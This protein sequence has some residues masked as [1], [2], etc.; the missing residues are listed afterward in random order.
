MEQERERRNQNSNKPQ[1]AVGMLVLIDNGYMCT[2]Y[3]EY[4]RQPLP[5]GFGL[6]T[7]TRVIC[8]AFKRFMAT[9]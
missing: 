7:Y 3:N 1:N 9:K 5:I 2:L 6:T 8:F 4:T